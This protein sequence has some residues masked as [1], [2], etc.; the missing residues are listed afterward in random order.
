MIYLAVLGVVALAI[1]MRRLERTLR[2]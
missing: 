1:A 2:S